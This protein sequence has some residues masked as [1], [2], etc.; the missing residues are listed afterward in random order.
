M[1]CP[2]NSVSNT[3][4][5]IVNA[6]TPSQTIRPV[7]YIPQQP[8]WTQTLPRIDPRNVRLIPGP[9]TEVGC[10]NI[11]ERNML[12]SYGCTDCIRNTN[13]IFSP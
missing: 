2:N 10:V 7:I 5:N 6:N 12:Y 11:P 13:V 9:I 1:S 3:R 8:I 4:R